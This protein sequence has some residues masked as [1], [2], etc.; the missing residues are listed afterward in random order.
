[1]PML[2]PTNKQWLPLWRPVANSH[3]QGRHK[4]SL[5]SGPRSLSSQGHIQLFLL[6]QNKRWCW[7]GERPT[8][9][10][11]SP[12]EKYAFVF[13]DLSVHHRPDC[14]S[15]RAQTGGFLWCLKASEMIDHNQCEQWQLQWFS[16]A[17]WARAVHTT[18][19]NAKHLASILN[20]YKHHCLCYSLIYCL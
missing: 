14:N 11:P 6:L 16:F 20:F 18:H 1:M 10:H 12:S 3:S 2:S 9:P 5:N 13:M 8:L 15:N 7:M 4:G 17:Y 19:P